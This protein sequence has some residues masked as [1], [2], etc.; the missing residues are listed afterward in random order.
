[1]EDIKKWC[2]DKENL[3]IVFMVIMAIVL[4]FILKIRFSGKGEVSS[5]TAQEEN[6]I[7]PTQAAD[8]N[9]IQRK[10]T[11]TPA[12]RGSRVFQTAKAPPFLERDLFSSR[13]SASVPKR[14]GEHVE[15]VE[16]ELTATII[17][18]QGALAII[19]NDVL[20]I[21]DMVQ[22]YQVT[23]IKKNAVLLSKGKRQHELRIKED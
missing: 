4:V 7:M 2:S 19:G 16:L 18:S 12:P 20:A 6:I 23:S 8:S 15:Q 21:G 1:M 9:I 11:R 5:A 17:D 22:G 10:V 14:K 3:K 13:I